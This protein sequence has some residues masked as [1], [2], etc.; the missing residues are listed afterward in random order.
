MPTPVAS[1]DRTVTPNWAGPSPAPLRHVLKDKPTED[2]AVWNAGVTITRLALTQLRDAGMP[3]SA[4]SA[5]EN[6][7]QRLPGSLPSG[8]I[9]ADLP[10]GGGRSGG[11]DPGGLPLGG[12]QAL[13]KK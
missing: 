13:S 3:P 11:S 6:L 5:K 1:G 10:S 4:Q 8:M 12:P 2:G 9:I 7:L